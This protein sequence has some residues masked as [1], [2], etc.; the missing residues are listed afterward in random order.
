MI[1]IRK[2]TLSRILFMVPMIMVVF[3]ERLMKQPISNNPDSKVRG[4]PIENGNKV[5]LGD[6]PSETL[7]NS[8]I[9]DGP[10]NENQLATQCMGIAFKLYQQCRNSCRY[11]ATS[12]STSN[13]KGANLIKFCLEKFCPSTTSDAY[14]KCLIAGNEKNVQVEQE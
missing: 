4:K 3:G 9:W 7:E 12:K 2:M 13:Q 5:E 14:Q 6:F 1:F 11:F 8:R 10:S